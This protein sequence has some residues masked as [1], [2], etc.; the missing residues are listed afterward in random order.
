MI[1][2]IAAQEV[3]ISSPN[4]QYFPVESNEDQE[5]GAQL[6]SSDWSFIFDT[7]YDNFHLF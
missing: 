5:G 7:F 1:I 2:S 4:G 3:W 6:I